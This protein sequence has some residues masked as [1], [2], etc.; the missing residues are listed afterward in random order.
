MEIHHKKLK[1]LKED[2]IIFKEQKEFEN[3]HV[4]QEHLKLQ[5]IH[6]H[7]LGKLEN[8]KL[9]IAFV[10]LCKVMLEAFEV[11]V[12]YHFQVLKSKDHNP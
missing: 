2:E 10:L 7:D 3:D 11:N 6:V 12:P 8:F 5:K 1:Q 4:I 9:K